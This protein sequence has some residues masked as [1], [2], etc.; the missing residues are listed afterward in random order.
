MT[1]SDSFEEKVREAIANPKNLGKME[2]ADAVGTV[3]GACPP[4]SSDGIGIFHFSE[5][6]G[7]RNGFTNLFFKGV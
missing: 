7:I 3:G 1:H 2:D 4:D 5:V 6:F